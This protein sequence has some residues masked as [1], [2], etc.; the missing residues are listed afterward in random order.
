MADKQDIIIDKLNRIEAN[1]A[2][3]KTTNPSSRPAV[4]QRIDEALEALERAVVQQSETHRLLTNIRK[5][6]RDAR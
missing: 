2:Q 3:N 5:G 6:L 1:I 4:E